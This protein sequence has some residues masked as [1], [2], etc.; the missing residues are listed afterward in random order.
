M[1]FAYFWFELAFFGRRLVQLR[2]LTC[3][4]SSF[5]DF[6]ECFALFLVSYSFVRRFGFGVE[7]RDCGEVGFMY[8]TV[9]CISQ[10]CVS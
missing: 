2:L 4:C 3:F 8:G 6:E 10:S 5:I 9:I 7:S 1:F